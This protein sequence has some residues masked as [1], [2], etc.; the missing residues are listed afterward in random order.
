MS[1]GGS[2][3]SAGVARVLST[4]D[5][6]L[7][8]QESDLCL[9]WHHTQALP[10]R[11]QRQIIWLMGKT[12]RPFPEFGVEFAHAAVMAAASHPRVT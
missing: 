1:Q 3:T 2:W 11:D 9:S 5:C 8:S 12:K 4:L 6:H 7:W 10:S